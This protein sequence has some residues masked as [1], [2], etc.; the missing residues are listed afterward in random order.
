MN[1]SALTELK[2]HVE[3]SVRPIRA[4]LSR[5]RR[6]REELLSHIVSVYQEEFTKIGDEQRA[7]EQARIRFG[8]PQELNAELQRSIFWS[9]WLSYWIDRLRLEPG[10]SLFHLVG[11]H[12]LFACLVFGAESL[13]VF[14]L[15]VS[16]GRMEELGLALHVFAVM[17]AVISLAGS[18][19][20]WMSQ[21]I[22]RALHGSDAER[23][24]STAI[25]Y[26][27]AALLMFPLVM[28]AMYWGLGYLSPPPMAL[29][30][31][32]VVS[33]LAPLAMILMSRQAADE[34]RHDEEWA[35]LAIEA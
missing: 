24:W 31:S 11:K 26:C 19:F 8:E 4:G 5:K 22:S 14:L 17:W 25:R 29:W 13:L 6:M 12:F 18:L 7:V 32:G 34:I 10:E 2:I 35:C 21:R 15:L 16:R 33:P 9:D 23:S 27:L 1:D 3:R 30:T 20:V 28:V